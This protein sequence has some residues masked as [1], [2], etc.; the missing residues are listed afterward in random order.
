MDLRSTTSICQNLAN[1]PVATYW[2]FGGLI[3]NSIPLICGGV[4]SETNCFRYQSG[5]WQKTFSL[6]TGR[7][8][9]TARPGSP[10]PNYSYL[11]TVI[12]SASIEVL[13][14]SGWQTTESSLPKSFFVSCMI[15]YGSSSVLLIAGQINGTDPVSRETYIYNA[16]GKTWTT[17]P[18]LTNGRR[19][20]GCGTIKASPASTQAVFIVAG[21]QYALR[22]GINVTNLFLEKLKESRIS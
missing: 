2:T 14:P 13:T 12:G 10:Y 3:N 15:P 20:M 19:A 18:M 21:G 7:Y 11:F 4:S 22:S 16:L 6:N 1:F 9:Y 5:S 17:S 8:F